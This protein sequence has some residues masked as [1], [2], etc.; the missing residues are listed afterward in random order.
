MQ[1][2]SNEIPFG[3]GETLFHLG[4]D[5]TVA[6]VN[7][8]GALTEDSPKHTPQVQLLFKFFN[9]INLQ[10]FAPQEPNLA[11]CCRDMDVAQAKLDHLS[12]KAVFEFMRQLPPLGARGGVAL[13]WKKWWTHSCS[14]SISPRI[15]LAHLIGQDGATFTFVVISRHGGSNNGCNYAYRVPSSS[16][17]IL[18][19]DH[20]LVIAP[21]VDSE[22][23]MM[24]RLQ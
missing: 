6:I 7:A 15:M 4:S 13:F 5:L 10:N 22:V 14:L 24:I 11:K 9:D 18:M 3:N 19:A 17:V 23:T 21:G 8:T 12:E 2:L 20:N 1:P 16:H